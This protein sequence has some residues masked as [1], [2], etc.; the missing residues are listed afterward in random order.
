MECNCHNPLNG[1]DRREVHD[2]GCASLE[3]AAAQLRRRSPEGVRAY[4]EGMAAA[5]WLAREK[6]LEQASAIVLALLPAA[7]GDF[8]PSPGQAIAW[9][10]AVEETLRKWAADSLPPG[11]RSEVRRAAGV[12]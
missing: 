11:G 10:L 3:G 5:I 4:R 2:P 8:G 7:E 6:G 9:E 1:D 12:E